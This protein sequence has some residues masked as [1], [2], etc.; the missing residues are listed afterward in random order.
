MKGNDPATTRTFYTKRGRPPKVRR[1]N[2]APIDATDKTKV[3]T[4]FVS[5][6]PPYSFWTADAVPDALAALERPPAT[7]TPLGMYVH[8]PFCRKR[9]SV[10]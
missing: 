7:D 8:I 4:Y 10:K 1:V 6:Y 2:D 9:R 3:G 5:N